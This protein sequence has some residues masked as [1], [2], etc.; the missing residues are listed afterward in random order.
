MVSSHLVGPGNQVPVFCKNSKSSHPLAIITLAPSVLFYLKNFS[1]FRSTFTYAV[2]LT[3]GDLVVL[4]VLFFVR[5]LA[6]RRSG[7]T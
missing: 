7:A 1:H 2:L 4:S 6:W 3:L 5:E